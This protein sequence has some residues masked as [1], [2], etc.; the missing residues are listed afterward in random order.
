MVVFGVYLL[1]IFEFRL[2]LADLS[3]K[4]RKKVVSEYRYSD[5]ELSI[6]YGG[7]WTVYVYTII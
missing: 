4:S 1:L 2:I 6:L 3:Y 5:P 7:N